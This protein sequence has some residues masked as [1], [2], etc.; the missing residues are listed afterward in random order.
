MWNPKTPEE[1]RCL[2]ELSPGLL[3]S[4]SHA[5]HPLL[6]I[7]R[8]GA[9]DSWAH[10]TQSMNESPRGFKGDCPKIFNLVSG[11]D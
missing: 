1:S 7:T 8:G 11:L 10:P 5:P 6:C 2:L 3:S 9:L 4:R